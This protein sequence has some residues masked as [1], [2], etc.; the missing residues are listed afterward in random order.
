[1]RWILGNHSGQCEGPWVSDPLGLIGDPGQILPIN[2]PGSPLGL[3]W[4]RER[5]AFGQDAWAVR[6]TTDLFNNSFPCFGGPSATFLWFGLNEHQFSGAGGPYPPAGALEQVMD[7]HFREWGAKSTAYSRLGAS[8]FIVWPLSD[9]ANLQRRQ[10]DVNLYLNPHWPDNIN[11][12]ANGDLLIGI[13]GDPAINF[14]GLS[15]DARSLQPAIDVTHNR[16]TE[17]RIPWHAILAELID[18]GHLDA[19]PNYTTDPLNPWSDT[20]VRFVNL[21]TEAKIEASFVPG[22]PFGAV[23]PDVTVR[24]FRIESRQAEAGSVVTTAVA[25]GPND[26]TI[27]VMGSGLYNNAAIRQLQLFDANHQPVGAPLAPTA[28]GAPGSNLQFDIPPASLV[29]EPQFL[30]IL[31]SSFGED[32]SNWQRTPPLIAGN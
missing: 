31:N 14:E 26:S 9:P 21:W 15:V 10:I 13:Y 12:D 18:R 2:T 23:L 7:L 24:D 19:P 6:L 22:T 11:D 27:S 5:N 32:D 16:P 30:R 1:P 4:I 8:I 17:V 28:S 25:C 20:E 29:A 3:E